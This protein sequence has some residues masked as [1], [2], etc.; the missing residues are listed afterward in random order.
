MFKFQVLITSAVVSMLAVSTMASAAYFF[1]QGLQ[2]AVV[3][4]DYNATNEGT[5]ANPITVSN[6]PLYPCPDPGFTETICVDTNFPYSEDLYAPTVYSQA[7][8]WS[9]NG[10]S[11][12]SEYWVLSLNNENW[13]THEKDPLLSN[14]GEPYNPGAPNLSLPRVEPG[15]GI[16]GFKPIIWTEGGENFYRFHLV[17]NQVWSNPQ[18]YGALPFMSIGAAHNRG[19]GS[20]LGY[21]NYQYAP[22]TVEWTSKVWDVYENSQIDYWASIHFF[23]TTAEWGGKTR[24]IQIALYHESDLGNGAEI[25]YSD[26]ANG[27]YGLHYHWNWQTQESFWYP[28]ADAAFMDAEDMYTL[29]GFSMTR[30]RNKNDS[31]NYSVVLDDLFRCASD[32]DLFD[33]D[34]PVS[35]AVPITDVHW[36]NEGTGSNVALWTSVHNMKMRTSPSGMQ[37]Q[38]TDNYYP[39]IAAATN[40]VPNEVGLIAGRLRSSCIKSEVC[41]QENQQYIDGKLRDRPENPNIFVGTLKE[42]IAT[43]NDAN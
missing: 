35:N 39:P 11:T 31:A 15:Y 22:S 6:N 2:S 4:T 34:M 42:F 41:W 3:R 17:M 13:Y 21:M 5:S 12:A 16:M 1:D 37:T 26:P 30:L 20:V 10:G 28:G 9:F 14:F 18:G 19:N 25:H 29:C 33:E 36:A 32:L 23:I 8:P 27:N 7:F 43:L 38:Y 40:E 24:M